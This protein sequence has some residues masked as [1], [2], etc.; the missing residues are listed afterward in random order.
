MLD[1][2]SRAACRDEEPELFFPIGVSGPALDQVAQAKAICER[3]PVHKDCLDW[4]L[5]T[6][7][8]A[9]IWGGTTEDE[10]RML[11]RKHRRKPPGSS[12]MSSRTNQ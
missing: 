12:G 11:H 1:W 6:G 8:N 2:R 9:G 5:T 10:R 7:Q 3:C 4:A